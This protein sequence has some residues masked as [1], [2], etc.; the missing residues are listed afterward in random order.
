MAKLDER[1]TT[2][3]D[4]GY[5]KVDLPEADRRDWLDWIAWILAFAG[6]IV[7]IVAIAVVIGV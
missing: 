7:L 1:R 4:P 5:P 6:L 3:E 2:V